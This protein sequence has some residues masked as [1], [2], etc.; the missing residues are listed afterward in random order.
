MRSSRQAFT[1]IELLIVVAIIAILAGLV[2]PV[3]GNAQRSARGIS[4]LNQMQQIGKATML[5]AADYDGLLPRSSH[6][7]LAHGA[8]PWGYALCT[9]LGRARYT[10]PS[11]EWDDLVKGLY[12]C[13]EDT[14][15]GQQWSYG[16]NVWFELTSGETGEIAGVARGR[17]YS[18][19]ENIPRPNRTIL[20]GELGSG[21]MGDHLMAHYWNQGGVPE[22]DA[23]R[24]G[25]RSNYIFADG[26]GET[27]EF[28]ATFDLEAKVDLWDPG[29]AGK[30]GKTN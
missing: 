28:S 25:D 5:Y 7:A 30:T 14:R 22:V 11:Q 29:K 17:T 26:H 13:P 12:H 15:E 16:K 23:T 21:S 4:C 8:K 20:Y 10:G 1:L 19:L 24:H 3:L 9:Y 6:S 18:H 27:L 2:L